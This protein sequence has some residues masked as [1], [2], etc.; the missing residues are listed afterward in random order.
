MLFN[1]VIFIMVFLPLCLLGWYLLQKLNSQVYAKIF[2]TLMS[3]WF[4]G[5]YNPWYLIVLFSQLIKQLCMQH[6]TGE[7]SYFI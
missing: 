5:Y 1:S 6:R 2:L 4:Y 3:L 7:D